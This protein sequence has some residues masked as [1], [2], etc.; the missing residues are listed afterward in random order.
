LAGVYRGRI[1][2]CPE[3]RPGPFQRAKVRVIQ[4]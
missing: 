4:P 2:D 1:P 3:G